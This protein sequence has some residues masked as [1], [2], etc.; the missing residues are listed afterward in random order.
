M[1][2]LALEL[3]AAGISCRIDPIAPTRPPSREVARVA[4]RGSSGSSARLALYVLGADVEPARRLIESRLLGE[5]S[6]EFPQATDEGGG[7]EVCP[8]CAAPITSSAAACS[9]CGLEFV[10]VE[11]VCSS[12][13]SVLPAEATTCPSCGASSTGAA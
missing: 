7:L 8:A 9:D 12:C 10:S 4:P 5:S 2:Q 6:G 1:Q 13:G 3:Q 11:D